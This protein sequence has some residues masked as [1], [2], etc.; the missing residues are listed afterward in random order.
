MN[1]FAILLLLCVCS[2]SSARA[3]VA[4]A[5]E[6]GISN[7]YMK[8]IAPTPFRTLSSGS[9]IGTKLGGIM[10]VDMGTHLYFQTGLFFNIKGNTKSFGANIHDTFVVNVDQSLQ[11]N[12]FELPI[13]VIFKTNLQGRGR[14]FFGLGA[15]VGMVV[16]GRNLFHIY[17][18]STTNHIDDETN[19]KIQGGQDVSKVDAGLNFMAGYEFRSGMFLRAFYNY[20]FTDIATSADESD[21]N[22]GYG[23]SMGFFLSNSKRHSPINELIAE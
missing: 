4:F 20:G 11:I 13:N 12:Y 23:I 5:P 16:G 8:I 15:S 1:K 9:I 22:R 17:G 7:C 14:I 10:D 3:Q 21:K 19:T 2:V 6:V 18:F